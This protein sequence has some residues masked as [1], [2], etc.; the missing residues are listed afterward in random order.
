MVVLIVLGVGM[1]QLGWFIEE[2]NVER[3]VQVDNRNKGT[4]TAWH[5]EARNAIVEFGTVDESNLA[6]RNALR[7]K[8]CDLIARL[9][10]PYRDDD[11]VAFQAKEC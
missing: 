9:D 2:K 8:A 5:D 6:A 1:W 4:Q 7:T 3:Q 10:T 11:L